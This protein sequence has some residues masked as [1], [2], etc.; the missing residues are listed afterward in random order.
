M[1]LQFPMRLLNAGGLVFQGFIRI[2]MRQYCQKMIGL[3]YKPWHPHT[4]S[5]EK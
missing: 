4:Q 1:E 5:T 3:L 2:R